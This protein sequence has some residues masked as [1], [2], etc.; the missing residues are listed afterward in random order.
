M[1]LLNKIL[2]WA[3]GHDWRETGFINMHFSMDYR[4]II[5]SDGVGIKLERF[6][7]VS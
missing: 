7:R 3:W 6:V 5:K 4:G 1:K 2:C